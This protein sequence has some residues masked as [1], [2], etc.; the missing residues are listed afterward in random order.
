MPNYRWRQWLRR[1]TVNQPTSTRRRTAQRRAITFDAPAEVLESRE[2]LTATGV[3]YLVFAMQPHNNAIAGHPLH[4]TVDVMIDVKTES[5]TVAEVDTAYNGTC[6]VGAIGPGTGAPGPGMF[7]TPLNYT[8]PQGPN[9]PYTAVVMPFINGVAALN[10]N[11]A[12]IDV[13]GTYQ[14][15]AGAFATPPNMNVPDVTS[16]SFTISPFTATDRLVFIKAP[17]TATVDVAI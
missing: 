17:S 14:L 5:G 12:A 8:G 16:R 9:S 4:F 1:I 7:D 2:L 13:A 6:T 10:Q 11:I 3:P 15:S